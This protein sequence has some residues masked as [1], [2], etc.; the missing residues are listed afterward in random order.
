[1]D[2]NPLEDPFK[3]D[4][5]V[6]EIFSSN[7]TVT[8]NDKNGTY[9]IENGGDLCLEFKFR[10]TERNETVLFVSKIQK[11]GGDE[12]SGN[13]LVKLIDGLAESIPEVKYIVLE[14]GSS[15]TICRDTHWGNIDVRLA[16]L[17][18]LTNG[19]SW[20]NSLGYK[21]LTHDDDVL[22]NAGIINSHMN[23]LLPEIYEK[24]DLKKF[25]EKAE[26]FFPELST[27]MTIKDYI[28]GMLKTLPKDK[29]VSK[30]SEEEINKVVLLSELVQFL[31][32]HL[33]Y[34]TH[35][36]KMV[37]RSVGGNKR[38][39]SRNARRNI[40]KRTIT[41]K[42]SRSARRSSKVH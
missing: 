32:H 20:Y 24:D 36:T 29:T 21:S 13:A 31:G 12:R 5:N 16:H 9:T 23:K 26:M 17:K 14:D 22:Y 18:I 37:Q 35:L 6:F 33:Q 19:L 4:H 41:R 40:K 39:R 7:F 2:D 38:K 27:D 3:Y 10:Q 8:K 42:R 34:N 25:N 28:T 15:I 30:H 1:M 11:C